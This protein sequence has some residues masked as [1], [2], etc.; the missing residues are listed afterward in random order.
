MCIAQRLVVEAEFVHHQN[1]LQGIID[2]LRGRGKAEVQK[3]HEDSSG[4]L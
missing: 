2:N 3:E 4:Q 1:T